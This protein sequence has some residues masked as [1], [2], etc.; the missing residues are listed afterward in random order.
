MNDVLDAYHY[1]NKAEMKENKD[2]FVCAIRDKDASYIKDVCDC[3]DDSD[4]YEAGIIREVHELA[5]V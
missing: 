2:C 4:A 5:G 1:Y 3:F